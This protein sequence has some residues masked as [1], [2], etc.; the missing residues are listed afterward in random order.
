MHTVYIL[1]FQ[2]NATQIACNRLITPVLIQQT[3]QSTIM[4]C[5][6]SS[7]YMFWPVQGYHQGATYKD[8]QVQQIMLKMYICRL[9]NMCRV[10]KDAVL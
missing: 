1:N 9:T 8:T 4:I 5:H 7:F 10:T 2:L 6:L 3:A